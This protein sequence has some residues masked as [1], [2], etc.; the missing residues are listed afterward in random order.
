MR[1]LA[2]AALALAAG[3]AARKNE[4]KRL[5]T[6]KEVIKSP[7]PRDYVNVAA[8]P[9]TY[10]WRNM[11]GVNY[12]TTQ[13]NQHIPK[14]CGSC[15]AHGSTSSIADRFNILRNASWPEIIPS[16]QVIRE[17]HLRHS[18]THPRVWRYAR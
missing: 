8:L 16:I 14:Y 13:L 7:L 18:R 2:V 4:V 1:T 15:W 3:V 10:D 9:T 5:A 11:S 12:V 17:G 6:V